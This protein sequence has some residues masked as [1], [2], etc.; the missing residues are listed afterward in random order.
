MRQSAAKDVIAAA[1]LEKQEK[2]EV[3]LKALKEQE[4]LMDAVLAESQNLKQEDEE[5]SKVNNLTFRVS[6]ILLSLAL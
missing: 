3:A 1:D 6:Q 5:N 2:E 4:L